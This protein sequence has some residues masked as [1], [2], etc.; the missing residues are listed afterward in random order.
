MGSSKT[1]H[2][3]LVVIEGHD[4]GKIFHLSPGAVILGRSK[5][6][7]MI[8]DARISREHV[9]IE[10]DPQLQKL[11]F[12]D[13]KSLNGCQINGT[14]MTT[15]ELKDG[16]KLQIG[17]TILD[18]HL[19]EAVE[20]TEELRKE[21]VLKTEQ[22]SLPESGSSN[23]SP[24]SP[25]AVTSATQANLKTGIA[26]SYKQ[27]PAL[28]V[29]GGVL[30]LLVWWSLSPTDKSGSNP[31]PM[32][33]SNLEIYKI[34]QMLASGETQNALSAALSLSKSLPNHYELEE[35]FGDIY[36]QTNQLESSIQNYKASIN[37]QNPSKLIHFNLTKAYIRAGL[38]A[39]A[40]QQLNTIDRLIKDSKQDK[41]LLIE[42]AT[43]LLTYP[44]LNQSIE[45][46]IVIAKSL[47]NDI[48]P[49][50][51]V[52]YRLEA[53][54]L[55]QLK[56]LKE[57]EALYE[58]A[59]AIAPNDLD[60]LEQL[61]MTKLNLQDLNGAKEVTE[62]WLRQNPTEVKALL[63]VSY[64]EFY[65]KKYLSTIPKLNSIINQLS[66]TPDNSRRLEALHLLGLVYWEQGQRAEA[67]H[68]LVESCNLGFQQS[69]NHP[70]FITRESNPPSATKAP[71]PALT[72]EL[73]AKPSQP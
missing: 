11:F 66:K 27:R 21:P 15:G 13:L 67:E 71:L 39:L 16:D 40:I 56:K 32:S 7:L 54:T 58:R 9:R 47:Q 14:G 6:N 25:A 55:I 31:A 4:K 53:S 42:F 41:E 23:P 10:F 44:E 63:A 73:P 46:A 1:I 24:E 51:T 68:Y 49:E 52:G 65:E 5:S 37:H 48:A 45:R 30:L 59:L 28:Y 8:N 72:P 29:V 57:A 50:S 64:I 70:A 2:P 36:F 38:I 33:Q 43:L 60:V 3:R 61:S 35:L 20:T 18:C 69:C 62:R 22:L 19:A 17:N 12:T 26:T 34:R